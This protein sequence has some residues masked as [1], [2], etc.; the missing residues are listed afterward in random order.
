MIETEHKI[1]DG[2]DYAVTQMTAMRAIRMQTRLIKLLGEPA[3]TLFIAASEDQK[4]KTKLA[5][6]FIPKAISQLCQELDEKSFENLVLELTKGVR[7]NGV[8][9]TQSVIDLEFAGKLSTLFSLLKFIIEVNYSDFFRE[10]G[11]FSGLMPSNEENSPP[12]LKKD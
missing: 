9:L 5:D 6:T 2:D 1:I 8:E 11:I 7:K 4:N 10:G 3:S 12:E